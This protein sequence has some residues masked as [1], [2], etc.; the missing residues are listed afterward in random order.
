MQ[1]LSFGTFHAT[2][3]RI[4]NWIQVDGITCEIAVPEILFELSGKTAFAVPGSLWI[5]AF[6]SI[7]GL[8]MP[9]Y[10]RDEQILALC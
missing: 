6:R 2:S 4:I 8:R 9:V 10:P 7:K 1:Q 3:G 5:I